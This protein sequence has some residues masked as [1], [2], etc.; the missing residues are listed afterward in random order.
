MREDRQ[1]ERAQELGGQLD[2][3]PLFWGSNAAPHIRL[4]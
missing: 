1:P 3:I 2:S 4:A